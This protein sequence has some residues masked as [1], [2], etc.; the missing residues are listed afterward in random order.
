MAAQ[1]QLKSA[2][3]EGQTGGEAIMTE[4]KK[5]LEAKPDKKNAK[6]LGAKKELSK[7]Q[8]LISVASLRRVM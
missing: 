7:A 8:T 3:R 1:L 2:A 5:K 4:N 6:K